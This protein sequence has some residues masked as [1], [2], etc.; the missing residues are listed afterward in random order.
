MKSIFLNYVVLSKMRI[1]VMQ[2]VTF[3]LGY[4]L[5]FQGES[6]PVKFI[7]GLVG[8]VL[9][10]AGAGALNHVIEKE[11]DKKMERTKNRPLPAKKM[12]VMHAALYGLV[13]TL[14]GFV[15]LFLYVNPLTGLLSF[16]TV[17]LYLF[18]Y[19][20][21]KKWSWFNT[22]AGAFPGAIPPLGGWAAA[23]GEL[24]SGAYIWFI[25]LFVWQLPHF[26]A[27]A[28]MYKDD[29]KA[30]GL[31]MLSIMDPEG[32]RTAR[33]ISIQTFFLLFVS[34]FPF[35]F[36]Q[37]GWLYVVG[38]IALWAWFMKAAT[39]FYKD[40]SFDNARKVLRVSVMYLPFL[41]IMVVLDRMFL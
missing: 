26:Y 30:G 18:F 15:V 9:T 23:T 21:M 12:G 1:L 40:R 24:T 29:Y 8:T 28:W 20:P 2:L 14:I 32:T 16:A 5:A 13:M 4:L 17:A 10:A 37:L 34:L 33:Q 31:K 36:Q 6:Y 3:A 11:I 25:I 22:L 41:L 38:A 7:W 27:I 35:V 39:I 19:T